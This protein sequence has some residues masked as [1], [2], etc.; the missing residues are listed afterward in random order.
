MI[1]P[2]RPQEQLSITG[3]STVPVNDAATMMAM[4]N[5]GNPT[6]G[7]MNAMNHRNNHNTVSVSRIREGLDVRT[8]VRIPRHTL[9]TSPDKD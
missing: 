9:L 7:P 1:A 8:T 5:L 3:R 4:V 2:A 6:Y